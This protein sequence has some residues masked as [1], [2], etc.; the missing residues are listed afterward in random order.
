MQSKANNNP[1][2]TTV[3]KRNF[4]DSGVLNK[5]ETE[6]RRTNPPQKSG[7]VFLVANGYTLTQLPQIELG[8]VFSEERNSF[9][10]A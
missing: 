5:I 6:K 1:V 3:L 2:K 9:S 10:R 7:I 4:L 8:L